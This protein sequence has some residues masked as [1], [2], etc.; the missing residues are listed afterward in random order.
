MKYK[1]SKKKAHQEDPFR[2]SLKK[3]N[4]ELEEKIERALSSFQD[5]VKLTMDELHERLNGKS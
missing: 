1:K 5:R 4:K 2:R 3:L